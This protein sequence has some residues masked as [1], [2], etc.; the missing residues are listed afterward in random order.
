MSQFRAT[1]PEFDSGEW[2][3]AVEVFPNQV[4]RFKSKAD[5]LE[6]INKWNNTSSNPAEPH[7]C[8]SVGTLTT[9]EQVKEHLLPN[10]SYYRSMERV[11]PDDAELENNVYY[12]PQNKKLSGI[13]GNPVEC[14][15]DTDSDN[16]SLVYD[17]LISRLNLPI[18][19]VMSDV[20]AE[21]TL[22]YLFFTMKCGI[23][24]MIKNGKLVVFCP[25][26]NTE[27][28]NTWA[29]SLKIAGSGDVDDYYSVKGSTENYLKDKTQW[30]ANGNIMCTVAVDKDEAQEIGSQ[31]FDPY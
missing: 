17:Y 20:S 30:W 21:N 25:F 8:H 28:R 9:W 29:N 16:G 10:I 14:D 3:E 5:C 12:H 23:Y 2:A 31:V 15:N 13:P 24:V 11:L 22:K 4:P 27:Y 18:H 7:L 26:V 19:R 6:F 1:F